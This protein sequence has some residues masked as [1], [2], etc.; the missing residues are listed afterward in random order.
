M[1]EALPIPLLLS[2]DGLDP[3]AELAQRRVDQEVSF[4]RPVT[5][6]AEALEIVRR[7][8]THALHRVDAAPRLLEHPGADVRADHFETLVTQRVCH[9]HGEA[10]GLLA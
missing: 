10:V 6:E 3:I 5:P 7:K 1:T 9:G 8:I 4:F 2:R